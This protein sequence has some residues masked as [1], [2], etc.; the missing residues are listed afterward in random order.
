MSFLNFSPS[1][2]QARQLFF[3]YVCSRCPSPTKGSQ[4]ASVTVCGEASGP[5][6]GAL[7]PGSDESVLR[8]Q[9]PQLC[10]GRTFFMR[11][12]LGFGMYWL[13]AWCSS[14]RLKYWMVLFN[15]S[16]SGT[17]RHTNMH[18]KIRGQ[19]ALPLSHNRYR[20]YHADDAELTRPPRFRFHFLP[21][22]LNARASFLVE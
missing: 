4:S 20:L 14:S 3:Y 8:E 6:E 16:S 5:S 9:E 1:K 10:R 7:L 2:T 18:L 15:P 13:L 12:A 11:A 17:C 19:A 21:L 22:G